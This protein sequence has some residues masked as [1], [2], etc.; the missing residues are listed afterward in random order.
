MVLLYSISRELSINAL[1]FDL[2]WEYPSNECDFLD[3][4]CMLYTGTGSNSQFYRT[5]DYN[6]KNFD[7][8][9]NMSHSGDVMDKFN[10]RGKKQSDLIIKS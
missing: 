4:T 1:T 8:I 7:D 3:G 6:K 9:P 10:K 5:F 2:F